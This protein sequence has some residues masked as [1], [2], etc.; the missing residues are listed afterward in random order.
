M[1]NQR[2]MYA[3]P[4][5]TL[6]CYFDAAERLY[7]Q[8]ELR[9]CSLLR[10]D[11]D[12]QVALHY[13]VSS[14]LNWSPWL[15]FVIYV[16]KRSQ[17]LNHEHGLRLFPPADVL[18]RILYAVHQEMTPLARELKILDP[19][20]AVSAARNACSVPAL[21]NYTMVFRYLNTR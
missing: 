4:F 21:K 2:L 14:K 8:R 15:V 3:S 18:L 9:H 16:E 7:V 19:T 6:P 20:A 11:L 1:P 12:L 10:S 17:S 5:L 13:A